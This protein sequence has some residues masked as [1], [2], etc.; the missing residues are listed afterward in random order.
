MEMKVE[1]K[2]F[3]LEL[4]VF[5]AGLWPAALAAVP[6][7]ERPSPALSGSAQAEQ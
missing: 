4:H 1:A 7:V 3:L 2:N 6:R 5:R